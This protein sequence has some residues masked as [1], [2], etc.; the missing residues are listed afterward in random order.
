LELTF[1]L[2]NIICNYNPKRLLNV[3]ALI[4]GGANIAFKND[5]AQDVE[6]QIAAYQNVN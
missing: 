2:S 6:K 4:G 3:Y 1:N 5:E